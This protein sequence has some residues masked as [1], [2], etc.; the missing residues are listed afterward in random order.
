MSRTAD[1]AFRIQQ[2][3][4]AFIDGVQAYVAKHRGRARGFRHQ[5]QHRVRGAP[6][7]ETS[8]HIWRL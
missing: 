6:A 4:S 8:G 2:P 1:E 3:L 7:R 5:L